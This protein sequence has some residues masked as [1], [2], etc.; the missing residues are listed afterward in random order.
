MRP[1]GIG[2]GGLEGLHRRRDHLAVLVD[3][4]GIGQI[5][6]L[7]IGIFDIADRALG[8][9]TLP[10]TPSLPLAPMPPGQSHRRRHADLAPSNP[11]R[12]SRDNR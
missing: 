2:G 6:L 5:V 8:L 1:I 7:G 10:A 3:H 12:L 9:A 4:I 11:A